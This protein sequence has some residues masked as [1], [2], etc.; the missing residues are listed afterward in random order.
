[1]T[2]MLERMVYKSDIYSIIFFY[3]SLIRYFD[4]PAPDPLSIYILK[5]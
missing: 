1:M 4:L 3:K 5:K 2:I